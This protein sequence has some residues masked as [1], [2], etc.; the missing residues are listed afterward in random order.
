MVQKPGYLAP[1][2]VLVVV[3]VL[4]LACASKSPEEKV[5]QIR[6]L[7]SAR[8]NGFLIEEEPLV[9]D[10]IGAGEIDD[11]TVADEPPAE[12]EAESPMDGE[13]DGEED[14]G[15]EV[16]QPVSVPVRQ[17]A[18]LDILIQNDSY[19]RLPGVTVD[20]SM[21]NS[22]G[23]EKNHWRV[24]FDTADVGK[25]SV[26]QF[27]H[28]LEDVSYEEGDGFFAEIRKPIPPEERSEYREFS[29]GLGN[30]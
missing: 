5:A 26:T 30:G 23:E 1:C 13:A 19:D 17:R 14:M 8:L 28:V 25:A 22:A 29:E 20:I 18:R 24:W 9:V 3:M 10:P 12:P 6:A 4:S 7:Y 27:T 11:P 2:L 16:V 21:A 15:E